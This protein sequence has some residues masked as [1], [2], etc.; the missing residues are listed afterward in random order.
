MEQPEQL[1]WIRFEGGARKGKYSIYKDLPVV[2]AHPSGLV[3]FSK[4]AMKLL[5]TPY[6][7][8]VLTSDGRWAGFLPVPPSAPDA[9]KISVSSAPSMKRAL[10]MTSCKEFLRKSGLMRKGFICVWAF[11]SPKGM[12]AVDTLAEP[13]DVIPYSPRVKVEKPDEELSPLERFKRAY[14]K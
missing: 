3:Y 9:K 11:E 6:F 4:E 12:I 2:I 10:P 14:P 8:P 1:N 5:P 13:L 7:A